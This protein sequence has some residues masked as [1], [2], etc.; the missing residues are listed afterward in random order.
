MQEAFDNVC[1]V[2]LYISLLLG[3]ISLIKFFILYIFC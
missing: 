2:G 1:A 3:I